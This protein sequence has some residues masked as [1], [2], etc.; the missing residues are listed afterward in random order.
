MST[1]YHWPEA[2]DALRN[3]HIDIDVGLHFTL[4]DESA[5]DSQHQASTTTATS[6]SALIANAYLRR[7]DKA[8]VMQQLNNQ[9]DLF[10]EHL[11]REPDFIDGH[12]HI[13]QLP[14]VRAALLE[15]YENR[16]PHH[17]PYIRSLA[18]I[19]AAGHAGIK[20]QI[21]KALG[22]HSLQ[23]SLR[24]KQIPHNRDFAGIYDFSPQ[25]DYAALM[26]YWLQQAEDG[27]LFMCHPG[28]ANNNDGHDPIAAARI[29]EYHY[30]NSDAFIDECRSANVQLVRGGHAGW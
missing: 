22:A 8:V 12:Q 5:L 26:R 20:P 6:L 10:R 7:L 3:S 2:A 28:V 9:L 19:K 13:H 17:R 21:I 4:I 18:H 24:D 15:V 29:N 16:F 25:H 30:L 11:G 14:I 1:A 27:A 23:R